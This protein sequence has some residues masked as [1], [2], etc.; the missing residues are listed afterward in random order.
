MI[1]KLI[2]HRCRTNRYQSD[3]RTTLKDIMSNISYLTVRYS[4][5]HSEMVFKVKSSCYRYINEHFIQG[6]IYTSIE[7]YY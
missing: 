5:T 6:P 3:D 1:K 7:A 2:I 4:L